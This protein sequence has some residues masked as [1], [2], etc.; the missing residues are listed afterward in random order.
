MITD[1]IKVLELPS[2]KSLKTIKRD[3]VVRMLFEK[4]QEIE[5]TFSENEFLKLDL[6]NCEI[7]GLKSKSEI[8][9]PLSADQNRIK[10]G[11]LPAFNY[12]IARNEKYKNAEIINLDTV[13][14]IYHECTC[15]EL[16]G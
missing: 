12:L 6:T 10:I 9:V 7:I 15:S 8:A 14:R 11:D 13:K 4:R 5:E 3:D 1:E 16:Q 2:I